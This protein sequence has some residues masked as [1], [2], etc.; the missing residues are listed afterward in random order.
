MLTDHDLLTKTYKAFNARNI[1]AVLAVMHPDVDWPNGLEGGRV[2]G[3]QGVRDYWM[4]Q[5][6]L[7]DPHVE[8][9]GFKT[10]ADGR[11]VVEVHQVVRDLDG[12]VLSDGEVQHVY[13]IQAGLIMSMEIR[14]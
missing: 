2:R 7:I 1:D 11:I 8:P 9:R 10:E 14:K 4:R 5:W 6:S 12:N 13:L 3:H